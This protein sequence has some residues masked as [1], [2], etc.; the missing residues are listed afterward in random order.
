MIHEERLSFEGG[1][2]GFLLF[3][4]ICW[5]SLANGLNIMF[6]LMQISENQP[7]KEY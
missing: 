6:L 1:P 7:L 3:G 4:V 5:L 2:P